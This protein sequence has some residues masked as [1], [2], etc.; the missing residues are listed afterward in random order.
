FG[1]YNLLRYLKKPVVLLS[2]K[3]EGHG[4]RKEPNRLDFQHRL[5]EYFDHYLKG[6]EAKPWMIEE[7]PYMPKK[8]AGKSTGV[9]WK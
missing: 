6:K 5:M 8:D 9:K 2:Y 1:Y 3:E 7:I 4:L